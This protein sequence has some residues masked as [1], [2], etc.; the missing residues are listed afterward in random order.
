MLNTKESGWGISLLL[1]PSTHR[2]LWENPL[3][4]LALF[5][6]AT[7]I[8]A[9]IFLISYEYAVYTILTLLSFVATTAAFS[10]FD[11]D[12]TKFFSTFGIYAILVSPF[13]VA[14][15]RFASYIDVASTVFSAMMSIMMVL[16]AA[17]L[18][19]DILLSSPFI[20]IFQ[21]TKRFLKSRRW[22]YSLSLFSIIVFAASVTSL[23]F[24]LPFYALLNL[25][26]IVIL[27]VATNMIGN[28]NERRREIFSLMTIGLNPD[29]LS[30][31][32]FAE[33]F[34]IGFLGGGVGYAVGLYVLILTA[35][36]ITT[37]EISTGWMIAV[38][39][40]SVGT[41][42]V[43]ATLPA[44]KSS[45]LYTPSLL[46][47]W[48]REAPPFIGLPPTWTFKIPVKVTEDNAEKLIDLFLRYVRMLE[49]F[50]YGSIERAEEIQ[51]VKPEDSKDKTVL[52]LK[53][54]YIFN[55][56]G[57]PMIVTENELRI[58][59]SQVLEELTAEFMIRVIEY[60]GMNI[61]ECLERIA[62]TYRKLALEQNVVESPS[63]EYVT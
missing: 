13:F 11:R 32:F 20:K 51:I 56:G 28:V 2:F 31:L 26:L 50:S 5:I 42:I 60:Q 3:L 22:R 43:S 45:M 21:L 24:I 15:S 40:L 62:S 27:V 33:A 10:L 7:V 30:G 39:L 6:L 44:I 35:L 57:N 37:L 46:K 52:K 16:T 9:G 41:A 58:L 63:Y 17:F 53:F 23:S 29:Q 14:Y 49:G 61:Y 34:I 36:P 48:W 55:E 47:R 4:L 38:I 12:T 1:N 59:R 18:A 25:F 54:K 19:D 8:S